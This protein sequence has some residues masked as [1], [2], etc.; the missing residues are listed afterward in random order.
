MT[1][2]WD[3][4]SSES[5]P[6]GIEVPTHAI[7]LSPH[8]INIYI[9]VCLKDRHMNDAIESPHHIGEPIVLV[10]NNMFKFGVFPEEV[11]VSELR[12]NRYKSDKSMK[13]FFLH[14]PYTCRIQS[15]NPCGP[16]FL[17]RFHF[18]PSTD[19]WLHPLWCVGWNYLFIPKLQLCNR[20]SLGMDEEFHPTPY[21]ACGYL[22]TLRLKLR[23]VSKSG[24]W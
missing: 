11:A 3:K 15:L 4:Q 23:N 1:S 9:H 6:H 18:N 24:A 22:S 16:F 10:W 8:M 13:A 5:S 19:K 21:W 14:K 20:W 12:S 7:E 17:T 2:S